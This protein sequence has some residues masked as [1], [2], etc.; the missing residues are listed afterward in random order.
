MYLPREEFEWR[1]SPI[2]CKRFDIVDPF[3]G[4]VNSNDHIWFGYVFV[5]QRMMGK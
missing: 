2:L 4:K 3:M 1:P 5:R